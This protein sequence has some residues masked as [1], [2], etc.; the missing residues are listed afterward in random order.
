MTDNE[1]KKLTRSQLL[2]LI[3]DLTAENESLKQQL[4]DV[5]NQLEQRK[6]MLSNA[7]SIAEASLQLHQIFDTA[8]SAADLYLENIHTMEQ[9]TRE[10]C[11]AM[12]RQAGLNTPANW[13][14]LPM[15]NDQPTDK[16]KKKG[17]KKK[18][19]KNKK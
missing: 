18:S 6:I 12:Q 5:Q 4:F 19:K 7:G 16:K 11:I 17:D 3:L 8:Q 9:E 1:L 2:E 10:R 14:E 15:S 13:G